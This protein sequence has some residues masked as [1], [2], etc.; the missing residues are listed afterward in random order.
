[1]QGRQLGKTHAQFHELDYTLAW[2]VCT[3]CRPPWEDFTAR[4]K[5]RWF[6]V[7]CTERKD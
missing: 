4:P 2:P 3:L 7:Y 6:E 1:M 5:W